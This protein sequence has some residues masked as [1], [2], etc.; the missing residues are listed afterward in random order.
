M[1]TPT[2]SYRPATL[3]L[4]FVAGDDVPVPLTFA[5][6]DDAGVVTPYDLT[7]ATVSA[8]IEDGK[9]GES[10]ELQVQF[11]DAAAGKVLCTLPSALSGPLN[12]TSKT[13]KLAW[14]VQVASVSGKRTMLTG[15]VV[16]LSRI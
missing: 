11:T 10:V 13:V 8:Y 9:P 3:N 1:S 5:M 15:T 4:E 12:T 6:Q 2:L 14:F 16:V 7:G